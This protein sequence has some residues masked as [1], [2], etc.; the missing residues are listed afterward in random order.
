[1]VEVLL[2]LIV[3]TV[4]LKSTLDNYAT[5]EVTENMLININIRF[6]EFIKAYKDWVKVI[7]IPIVICSMVGIYIVNM[8]W[9]KKKC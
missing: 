3:A 5:I 7:L 4:I 9:E 1:M 6:N 8:L 2:I